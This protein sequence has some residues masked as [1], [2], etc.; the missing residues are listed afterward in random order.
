MIFRLTVLACLLLPLQDDEANS[1]LPVNQIVDA[2]RI[3]NAT[4]EEQPASGTEDAFDES[5]VEDEQQDA[6]EIT[7]W[8]IKVDW[9]EEFAGNED[10]ASEY[11][12]L[13]KDD[14]LNAAA[15]DA[16]VGMLS[17]ALLFPR[18]R[19]AVYRS[20]D[21]QALMDRL[22]QLKLAKR[23]KVTGGEVEETAS[24]S[25]QTASTSGEDVPLGPVTPYY[26]SQQLTPFSKFTH[27]WMLR[28]T[29]YN[30]D[31]STVICDRE[32]KLY[33][34]T[35]WPS[36]SGNIERTR[37][38][39]EHIGSKFELPEACSAFVNFYDSHDSAQR[40][41]GLTGLATNHKQPVSNEPDTIPIIQIE[42]V[43]K[44]SVAKK[45]PSLRKPYLTSAISRFDYNTS[46]RSSMFRTR[47]VGSSRSGV[48]DPRRGAFAPQESK[49]TPKPRELKVYPLRYA[50]ASTV[51]E[52]VKQLF[53]DSQGVELSVDVR[54]NSLFVSAEEGTDVT[55]QI[56]EILSILDAPAESKVDESKPDVNAD[57]QIE[58]IPELQ[59][60]ILK[61]DED[62]V[63]SVAEMLESMNANSG[64]GGEDTETQL[65]NRVINQARQV[66]D[67][68]VEQSDNAIEGCEN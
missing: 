32:C 64:Y 21:S 20:A 58:A 42:R 53:P 45:E 2:N 37:L 33:I 38:Q 17:R 8:Q 7:V 27:E 19:A 30:D 44:N 56:G 68:G 22:E 10:F 65:R 14:E 67:A 62:S 28:V 66:L 13:Y 31:S 1:Q 23:I 34:E 24:F 41:I 3:P 57:V 40:A 5:Q 48:S 61:G 43:S 63:N 9:S 26:G 12:E 51:Y 49:Q 18:Q 15:P 6:F 47:S 59:T 11:E 46:R 4:A 39:S 50:D 25:F 52:T 36:E 60:F 55:Q 54:T 29:D 16:P 35:K